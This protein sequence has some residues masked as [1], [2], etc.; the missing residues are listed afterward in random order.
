MLTIKGE[1]QEKTEEKKKDYHLQ[2]RYFGAFERSFR[3]PETVDA[4]KI[5]AQ[6]KAG[7]LTLTLPKKAGSAKS[8][9][10]IDV[11]AA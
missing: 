8:E 5:D 11:K 6:F 2:E 4:D 7:V 10:K 9:K 3:L 1:K